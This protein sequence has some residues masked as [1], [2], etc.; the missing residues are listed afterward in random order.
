MWDFYFNVALTA[1]N[2]LVSPDNACTCPGDT[3]TYM[4]TVVGPGNTLWG[5]TAFDCPS[6]SNEIVLRHSQFSELTGD[7][8][9]CT[10]GTIVGRSLGVEGNCYISQLSITAS[11]NLNDTTVQ[12][13]HDDT[14]GGVMVLINTS[15]ISV[16]SG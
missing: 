13:V 6:T 2:E 14:L 16:I 5:G 12:C 7:F 1:N 10:N 8:G 4:C 11:I 9:D 3:I 15:R